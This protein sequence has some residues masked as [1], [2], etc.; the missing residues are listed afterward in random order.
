MALSSFASGP[1]QFSALAQ[2]PTAPSE[3]LVFDPTAFETLTTTITTNDGDVEVVYHFWRAIPYV[4]RPVDPEYQTLNVSVPVS[5]N[6]QPVDASSVPILFANSVG[7]YMPSYVGG[8]KGVGGGGMAGPNGQM[9]Q[10][11]SGGMPPG[12]MGGMSGPGG[13]PGG[14]GGGPPTGV[15]PSG[16]AAQFARGK[17]VSNSKLALAAGLVVVEPGARGRTQTN[18][19]GQYYGVAPAVIVD[20]KAA[21]RYIRA[22]HGRIPGNTDRIISSGTSAGG[23]V[24][25][26][27]G[28]TGDSP[29]YLP[30]LEA[31]GAAEASDAIFATGAWCP[32]T[33]LEHADMAYE[34]CWGPNPP[35]NGG[36]VDRQL[37]ATLAT[38][39]AGYQ[40]GLTLEGLNGFGPLRAD[41]Y[42][43]YLIQNQLAPA[44]TAYLAKLSDA[45]R[46]QYLAAHPHI[47]WHDDRAHFDWAGFVS[48]VGTRKKTLP[49]FDAFDLSAGENNLFGFGTTKARHFTTFSLENAPAYQAGE[50]LGPEIPLQV[51][52]MNPMFYLNAGHEGRSRHWWLRTGS[53]DTDT[54]LTVISNLA[55]AA[56]QL[57]DA[58][59]LKL[60]WDAGHGANED[61]EDFIRWI[62]E[63]SA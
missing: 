61:A 57:G 25:A 23:A 17:M 6:G 52:L 14:P 48:H 1:A 26:L 40:E 36:T 28:A 10:G 44:A 35:A 21:V 20:L 49:A 59:N 8:A 46:T 53:S 2:S 42:G 29:N 41:N 43:A 30:F 34:W 22:N 62:K 13:G 47:G 27:L 16:S 7:G 51:R 19:A 37:S 45:D 31:L 38:N 3:G 56:A 63:I 50:T 11:M 9:P 15:A 24:S 5:I 60:Y 55:S 39:F 58:V 4:A 18:A 32:I 54:S 33:D 12:M